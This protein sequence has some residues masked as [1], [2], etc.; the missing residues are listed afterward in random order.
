MEMN[1]FCKQSLLS[2]LMV[3]VLP[4][5]W[6]H[7]TWL[8]PSAGQVEGKDPWVTFDAAVS[9]DLFVFGANAVKLDGL[10]IT[11]PDG[12]ALTPENPFTGKLRSSFDLKLTA[13]GTYRVAIVSESV[14]AS[15]KQGTETKRFRGTVEAFAKE[16]LADAPDLKATF[17]LGRLETF[18]TFGKGND[19]AF[20]PTGAGLELVPLTHPSDYVPGQPARFRFML[21]GKPLPGVTVSVVPGG[22]RY[23]GVL[24]EQTAKTD[25]KGEFNVKW[26]DA[27]LYA[28]MASYPP[29]PAMQQPEGGQ[30]S[31]AAQS[32]ALAKRFTY[33]G[34][35]EVLPE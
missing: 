6:A 10:K 4:S 33:S 21:D 30:Q 26:A 22:V 28:V 14:M 34:T 3:A 9:E 2:L 15:Y 27:G 8:I 32:E 23:R 24:G 20:K 18:V 7:R 12:S 11:A 1:K 17:T 31:G 16:V 29:R 25:A 19:T 13:P 35:F 5:A